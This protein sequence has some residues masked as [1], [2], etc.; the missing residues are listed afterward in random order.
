M[1]GFDSGDKIDVLIVTAA[2][3]EFEA[4]SAVLK[5]VSGQDLKDCP[6][7]YSDQCVLGCMVATWKPSENRC[8]MMVG[9]VQQT[10]IGADGVAK[11]VDVLKDVLK[12]QKIVKH[13]LVAMIGMCAGNEGS[14]VKLGDVL[15]PWEIALAGEGGK[16]EEKDF[17]VEAKS[18]E[19][20]FHLKTAVQR[21]AQKA[22]AQYD[23]ETNWLDYI[24]DEFKGTPSPR[25]L[26]DAT[27]F[28]LQHWKSNDGI[29]NVL[30][31]YAHLK[32]KYK[33]PE[34]IE[35]AALNEALKHLQSS[36]YVNDVDGKRVRFKISDKG[37]E[38]ISDT[39]AFDEFPRADSVPEIHHDPVIMGRIVNT[40]LTNEDDWK[41]LKV[42]AAKRKAIGYEMEGH[43]FLDRMATWCQPITSILIKSVADFGTKEYKMKVKYYQEYV[44]AVATAFLIH[45]LTVTEPSSWQT[46]A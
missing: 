5:K 10:E 32:E 3:T 16:L 18:A 44:T 41:Q 21:A 19:L 8:P 12:S 23:K 30:D 13:G 14:V 35:K 9:V 37:K 38:H 31:L 34:L 39:A 17:Q 7:H 25:Y 36:E 29:V 2:K 24:P 42:M 45:F 22:K 28:E 33:W 4:V 26:F 1:R 20:P 6:L 46:K 27:L 43:T 40:A 15:V 11:I